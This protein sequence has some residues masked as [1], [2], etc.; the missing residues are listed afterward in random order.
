MRFSKLDKLIADL[1]YA[2]IM[3]P[4]VHLR[5][6]RN[7]NREDQAT[8]VDTAAEALMTCVEVTV[9]CGASVDPAA[10][11]VSNRVL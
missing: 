9:D 4:L 2:A 1:R 3:P 10:F 8:L 7:A 5:Q 11:T 6:H